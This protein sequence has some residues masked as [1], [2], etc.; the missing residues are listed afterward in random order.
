MKKDSLTR[1]HFLK[2]TSRGVGLAIVSSGLMGCFDGNDLDLPDVPEPTPPPAPIPVAFDH[3]VASGDPTQ[4]A[5]ILWT[6]VT[7]TEDGFDGEIP[8]SWEVASDSDFQNIVTNGSANISSETDYTLKIDA[9]DLTP[10]TT[11]FYR[12]ISEGLSS[13]VGNAKTLP[14]GNVTS[15]KLAVVSCSN[16]PAGYFNVYSM[17][18]EQDDLDAVLHLGDYIYEYDRSGYA[19]ENAAALGREVLPNA[20]L[21][22]LNDYRTRYAQYRTDGSLQRLHAAV[23]F[24]AVWD[25]HEVT[26]DTWRDGAENHQQ[27]EGDFEERKLAALQAYFEWMPIRPVIEN[28]QEI[29]NRQFSFGNLVE[30]YMLDTRVVARDRQLDYSNYID[31]ATGALDTASF[32][33]D[34]SD[35]N[36]T[37]LGAEQLQWLQS[38]MSVSSA[39]WQVL[40]QQVLMGR[41]LLPAAIATLQLSISEYAEL[42]QLAVLAQRAEAGD[43]TLTAEEL[44]FLQANIARLTPEVIALLSLPSIP[45]NLDAWDGYAYEREVILATAKQLNKNLVVLA[46]DTHNAW[47][48][49]L[50]DASGDIVGV[51]FATAS[52]SS[53]GLED[54]L[55]I[56]PEDTIATEAG[57]V[58]LVEDLQYVNAM[59]R[60][61]MTLTFT[62]EKVTTQ[63]HYVDTIMSSEYSESTGR[64]QMAETLVGS[65]N[66]N[67]I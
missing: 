36:R 40:G 11:Y 20:E 49:N 5:I 45:Y 52:V 41:M 58:Q 10:N 60:G 57:I 29:I 66:V 13:P 42:A 23:P 53:P 32:T 17:A 26:N 37:M 64:A 7:P 27:E 16:Y 67:L 59:D 14:D 44:A 33:A 65:P 51:E 39:T 43:P 56:A 46:G 4:S 18:A 28:D 15:V 9:I 62:S 8:V 30:L 48:N 63:W 34:V 12:F 38:S 6:R 3:G 31:P 35:S 22:S 19:S 24:I 50:K 2:L 54:Y 21:V 61:F 55:S 25:D 47:S 1:R